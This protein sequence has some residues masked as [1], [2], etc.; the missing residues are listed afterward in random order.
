MNANKLVQLLVVES[1]SLDRYALCKSLDRAGYNAQGSGSVADALEQSADVRFD[2][3][4]AAMQ[5]VD[6]NGLELLA[7]LT[8]RKPEACVILLADELDVDMVLRAM[9]AGAHDLLQKPYSNEELRRVVQ[10]GLRK[11]QSQRRQRRL[12]HAI[13]SAYQDLVQE[14]GTAPAQAAQDPPRPQRRSR[15]TLVQSGDIR[16]GPLTILPSKYQIRCDGK[17]AALTPTEFDLLLYLAA[18]RNRVLSCE[19]LLLELRGR[20]L[21][22]LDARGVLRPHISNLRRKVRELGDFD[23]VLNVRG[24]GYRLVDI[25]GLE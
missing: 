10:T 8:E 25:D 24:L 16:L 18:N 5:L 22:D 15:Q 17:S 3:I 4:F 23:P 11:V 2:L 9:R 1:S 12:M 13:G 21:D 6:G 14:L 19:E 7:A 20:Q